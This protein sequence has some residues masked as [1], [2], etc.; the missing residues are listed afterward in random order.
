[1]VDLLKVVKR[2]L[3]WVAYFGFVAVAIA[4]HAGEPLFTADGPYAYGKP[5]LWFILLLFLLYTLQ[6]SSQENFFASLQ[7]MNSI[8]WSRQVGLDLYIGLLIPLFIIYLHE[9][10]L[11]VMV[12]WLLPVLVF[13]NLATL[14]YLALNYQSL[15][16]YFV[17]GY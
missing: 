4:T 14:L 17:E 13:A 7:R 8:L 12:L 1:M 16:S 10:S 11:L 9:G 6:I 15:V 5:M 3:L 2:N